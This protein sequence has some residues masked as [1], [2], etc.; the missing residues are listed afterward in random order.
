MNNFIELES[1]DAIAT[2]WLN[3]P[4]VLNALNSQ[5]LD[6]LTDV[7]SYVNSNPE[8]RIILLRGK[9]NAFCSGA[10]LN[11]LES[12]STET[13]IQEKARKLA[14]CFHT[15][16]ISAK[17]VISI[18]HGSILGG[19]NGLI[20]ASD[21]V[22]SDNSSTFAF[23]E[24]RIG[25]APSTIS[26]YVI[27]KI[28]FQNAKRLLFTGVKINVVEAKQTGLIDF[29]GNETGVKDY[30]LKLISDLLKASPEAL[31]ETKRLLQSISDQDINKEIINNTTQSFVKMKMGADSKEGI[32]AF[33]E[34]RNPSWN[35]S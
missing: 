31:T 25:L 19:A 13:G 26:P 6:A 32:S 3:R 7:I 23:P 16:Y 10:D 14:T 27:R 29:Y 5:L 18:I 22:I 17:P 21:F 15:I 28:G 20:C 35:L 1:N 8:F 11:W 4:E 9:G 12:D 30:T 33:R 34:K 2:L 24:V